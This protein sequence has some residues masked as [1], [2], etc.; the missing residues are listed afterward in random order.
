MKKVQDVQVIARRTFKECLERG[1]AD[2]VA[3]AQDFLDVRLHDG[4]KRW[5]TTRPDAKERMLHCSARWGKDLDIRT[6]IPTPSGWATMG[7]LEVG[8]T[9]LDEQGNTCKVTFV[10]P[11]MYKN[12][13]Y[14]I[15]FSNGE[16]ITAGAEHQWATYTKEQRDA[17]LVGGFQK[18]CVR[19]TQNIFDTL[20]DEESKSPNHSVKVAAPLNLPDS[21]LPIEPEVLGRWLANDGMCPQCRVNINPQASLADKRIPAQYLRA[22]YRQRI[23]LLKGLCSRSYGNYVLRLP[24]YLLAS[25]ASEL[26]CTLGGVPKQIRI[27]RCKHGKWYYEVECPSIGDIEATQP[28]IQEIFIVNVQRRPSVPTKCIQV[29]SPSSTYL[30]GRSFVCTHNTFVAGIKLI[31]HAFYQIRDDKYAFQPN[32]ALRPYIC[33]NI[34]MS[35]DQARI[36]WDTVL[37]VATN[38]ARFGRFLVDSDHSPFPVLYI[39]NAAT[40]PNRIVS[41]V[42]ARSTAKRAK[43]LLG[44]HFAFINYDEAAFDSDGEVVWNDVLRMRLADE[45]G[46]IDFTSTPNM[47]NWFFAQCERGRTDSNGKYTNPMCYTQK[48]TVFENPYV[49]HAFIKRTMAFMTDAQRQQNVYGEFADALSIFD[50]HHVEVCYKDH[51]YRHLLPVPATHD[52]MY[53]ETDDGP[54]ATL[55]K[56]TSV[57]R[58]VIGVD[59]ARKRDNTCIIVLRVDTQPARLVAYKI[60]SRTTWKTIYEE[61][62]KAHHAYLQAPILVDSTGIGDSP[63]EA[64]KSAPYNL[65]V[66]GYNMAGTGRDKEALIIHLQEAI[67]N[68]RIIFPFIR[69][70]Y[71]QL[72]YYSWQDSGL[73][74]DALFALALA[75]EC[76]LRQANI[77]GAVIENHQILLA[78]LAENYSSGRLIPRIL[79]P[80]Q[81]LTDEE[82]EKVFAAALADRRRRYDDGE[83]LDPMEYGAAVGGFG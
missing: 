65:N 76:A 66:A 28:R 37:A 49:D 21:D 20:L 7:A 46:N 82:R 69:E 24:R 64:L 4:Q 54:R 39:S 27:S 5:L 79:E 51:D 77:G 23:Q 32:G 50:I 2:P 12:P 9:V 58:Y 45:N 8:D 73:E 71:E 11:I 67:Q 47:K 74:T 14:D 33:A 48:G 35:M 40:G 59:L 61:V 17:S 38:S 41:E 16:V 18:P 30:A 63:F 44:K 19:T 75:W 56:S 43:Y 57:P 26:L 6:P 15:R 1:Y 22:S 31:H 3:F 62:A 80:R 34:A 13:C 78:T 68:Q 60:F 52:V 36:A 70:L 81:R 72:I 29:D 53:E 10:T 25:D 55:V 83:D 42:W